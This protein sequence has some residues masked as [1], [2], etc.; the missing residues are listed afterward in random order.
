MEFPVMLMFVFFSFSIFASLEPIS[1]SAHVLAIIDAA[2]DQVE[3]LKE[4]N[5][6]DTDGK[7]IEINHYDIAFDHVDF[8]Y[9]KGR[10]ILHAVTISSWNFRMVMI[11]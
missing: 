6:I 11:R 1:D 5:F 2:M 10:Q 3:A 9:E 8:S 7:S 4:D